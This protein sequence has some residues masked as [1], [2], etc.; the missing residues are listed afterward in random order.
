MKIDLHFDKTYIYSAR[1]WKL[2][3]YTKAIRMVS[4][5]ILGAVA[6]L[7]RALPCHGRGREFESR[8]HR[9]FLP[10][11]GLSSVG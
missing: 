8:Q 9:H 7:V 11:W 10:L 3:M 1:I 5:I 4:Q 6:Q 2:R